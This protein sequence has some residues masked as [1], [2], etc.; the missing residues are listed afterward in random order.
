MAKEGRGARLP[1]P[2][3]PS[4]DLSQPQDSA[5]CWGPSPQSPRPL[6]APS[7]SICCQDRG[8]F[9]SQW[10]SLAFLVTLSEGG[11][12]GGWREF[13]FPQSLQPPPADTHGHG[14]IH[15]NGC[16]EGWCQGRTK[17][18]SQLHSEVLWLSSRAESPSPLPPALVTP[19][20]TE[21]EQFLLGQMRRSRG[22]R[23]QCV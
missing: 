15:H 5:G 12:D 11:E 14:T 6:R 8:V 7:C 9:P 17:V 4:A 21:N 19:H 22:P 16:M 13:L 18:T 3:S 10:V 23:G 20:C 1:S 2:E